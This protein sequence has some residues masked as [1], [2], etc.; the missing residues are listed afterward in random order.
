MKI[1]DEH[2]YHGAMLAQIAEHQL[3]TAINAL[4]VS[5]KNSR[6]AYK[7]NDA[8]AVYLKYSNKPAGRYKEYRFT[9]NKNHLLELKKISQSDHSLFIAMSCFKDR[10]ICCISYHELLDLIRKRREAKGTTEGQYIVICT[11]KPNE[12]FRVNMNEPETKGSS[13][14]DP[15][16]IKRSRFPNVIFNE[17]N[18]SSS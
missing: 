9:F 5:G 16:I 12:S 1:L 18:L 13:V 14:S 17:G 2:K 11:L 6:S 4:K 10:E 15:L 8:I 7:I 3:L